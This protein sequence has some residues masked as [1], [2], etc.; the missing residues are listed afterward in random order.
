MQQLPDIVA[1]AGDYS[2]GTEHC[3]RYHNIPPCELSTDA[4]VITLCQSFSPSAL[5]SRVKLSVSG[6]S[7]STGYINANMVRV[8]II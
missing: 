6:D 4:P 5:E 1:R 8:S 7:A 2:S 3:N